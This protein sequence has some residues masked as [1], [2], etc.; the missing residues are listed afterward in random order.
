MKHHPSFS[1]ITYQPFQLGSKTPITKSRKVIPQ[2]S[3]KVQSPTPV[4]VDVSLMESSL[5]PDL[6]CLS[7]ASNIDV[8]HKRKSTSNVKKI[9]S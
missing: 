1:V 3:Q 7:S 4:G 6:M 8:M 5:A 2:D 9:N